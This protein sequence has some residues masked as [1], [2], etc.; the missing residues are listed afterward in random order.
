MQ[1]PMSEPLESLRVS[2]HALWIIGCGVFL[3][4]ALLSLQVGV[5]LVSALLSLQVGVLNCIVHLLCCL[6]LCDAPLQS[7]ACHD[8]YAN[9]K[10]YWHAGQDMQHSLGE[11]LQHFW[12]LHLGTL[13][14]DSLAI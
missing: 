14:W 1:T 10:E 6:W 9:A 3:V 12:W 4:R 7:V 13:D 8:L 11:Q 5:F 2:T